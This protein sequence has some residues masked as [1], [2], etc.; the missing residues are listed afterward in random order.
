MIP[1]KIHYCWFGNGEKSDLI[2]KCINS[3]KLFMPDYEI[4]EWNEKNFILDNRY[5]KEAYDAKCYAFVSDYAR[6]K[7]IYEHGGIYLDTDV[8]LIKSLEPLL[9]EGGH[10]GFEDNNHI[11]TGLGFSAAAGDKTILEMLKAYENICFIKDGVYD[12]TPCPFRN[13]NSLVKLGLK[14]NNT[15]QKLDNIT[16][17]P[18]HFFCPMNY[19]TGILN[20]TED[21][22]SIHHYG[23]SWADEEAT[24][25]LAFK[26]KVFKYCPNF[27]AQYIFNILNFFRRKIKRR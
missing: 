8:E 21:T 25:V 9:V 19:D 27:C 23:Y 4:I 20:I 14:C 13:T 17:Y 1:K 16:V 12:K 24:E 18:K 26:R 3:W 22:Y 10:L 7:I 5:A 11:N 15:K 2:K 6:L